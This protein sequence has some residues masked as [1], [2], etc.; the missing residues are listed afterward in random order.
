[1][2]N[3]MSVR[4]KSVVHCSGKNKGK[5]IKTHK[6]RAAAVRQHKAIMANK[7]KRK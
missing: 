7:K 1:V 3:K 4:G 2:G 5:I 6:S